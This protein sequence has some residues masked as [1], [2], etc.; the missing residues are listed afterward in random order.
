[1][2]AIEP[3]LEHTGKSPDF[4]VENAKAERFYVEALQAGGLSNHKVAAQARLNMALEAIDSTP[5]PLHFLDLKVTGSP[6]RPLSTKKLKSALKS[7][8]AGLPAL[9][10]TWHEY[11]A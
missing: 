8:I 1:M 9:E 4:L 3:K 2:L 7:W 6:T 5:S 10:R 11:P